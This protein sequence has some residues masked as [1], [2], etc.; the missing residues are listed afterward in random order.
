MTPPADT[1]RYKN[2]RFPGEIISHGGFI[3][4]LRLKL[5]SNARIIYPVPSYPLSSPLRARDFGPALESLPHL[6]PVVRCR[7][8]VPSGAKVLGDR[9]IR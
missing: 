5:S 9:A 1:E 6:L 4:L 8:Q 2:H 3:N 7:Q